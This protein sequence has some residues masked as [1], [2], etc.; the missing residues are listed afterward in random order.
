MNL[1]DLS[2][3]AFDTM[4]PDIAKVDCTFISSPSPSKS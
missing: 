1:F 4:N 3:D 2:R